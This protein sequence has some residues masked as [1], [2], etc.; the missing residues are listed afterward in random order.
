MAA[1]SAWTLGGRTVVGAANDKFLEATEEWGKA[2]AAPK[3]DKAKRGKSFRFGR[4]DFMGE[5]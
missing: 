2:G 3:S 4:A 1:R 5:F